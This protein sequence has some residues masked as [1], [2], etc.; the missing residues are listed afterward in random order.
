L[1]SYDRL[2]KILSPFLLLDYA[3]PSNFGPSKDQRGVGEHPH[4]GFETVTIVYSGEVEHRDTAG[5][6]GTIGPGD[7]QWMTAGAGVMHDEFHSDAF[8][9]K[10]G[11]LK[12]AQIW[13]NLPAQHKMT[14]PRYQDIMR[15]DIPGVDLDGSRGKIRV[16]AGHYGAVT[17]PAST[18]SELNVWDVRLPGGSQSGIALPEG[19]NSVIAVL[20]GEVEV[21]AGTPL[22]DGDVAVL[23]ANGSGATVHASSDV[24]LLVLTGK[25]IEEP[26]VGYGP[27]VMNTRE[28][29]VAAFNDL[30]S[31]RFGHL[32]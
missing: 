2:G 28:E 12:M 13:I 22:A 15:N 21:G 17:G 4:R 8:T 20:G 1:F 24:T 10:G 19:H 29:I 32:D 5:N 9:R 31:G 7:V 25:P 3:G 23:G 26:I 30:Q 18:F 6:S 11:M 27:F 16:I 14:P